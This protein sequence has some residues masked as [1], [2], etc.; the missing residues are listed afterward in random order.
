MCIKILCVYLSGNLALHATTL[1]LIG[2]PSDVTEQPDRAFDGNTSTC[3]RSNTVVYTL[4]QELRFAFD[5]KHKV[6]TFV[7]HLE[8]DTKGTYAVFFQKPMKEIHN[9]YNKDCPFLFL[10]TL[11]TSATF[12]VTDL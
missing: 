11:C 8:E 6:H 1:A 10:S 7:L 12:T 5:M 3:A 4:E 9:V 2:Q